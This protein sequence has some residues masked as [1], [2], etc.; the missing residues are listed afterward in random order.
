MKKRSKRYRI[1]EKKKVK[2]KLALDKSLDLVKETCTTKMDESIDLSIKINT[3]QSKCGDFNLRTVVKLPH[4]NG[5]KFKI[6]VLCEQEK[7]EEAKKIGADVAG[8]QDLLDKISNGELNFDKLICTPGMMSKI[9][10]LGK[11][12]GPKGLMPNPKLGTVSNDL[13]KSITDIKTGLVEIKNDKDGNLALSIGRKNFSK[14]KLQ[15]NYKYFID[16][17]KKEKPENIKGEFIKN[18]FL[19]STMGISYKLGSKN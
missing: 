14:E 11:I 4:G 1:I 16:F 15:E 18:I 12:L 8:S 13:K 9:G 7:V 2:E 17:L 5:K 10:K 6:A 19:T 3:K